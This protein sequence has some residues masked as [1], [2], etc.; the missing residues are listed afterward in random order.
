MLGPG[1]SI[2]LAAELAD[3]TPQQIDEE[4]DEYLA[5]VTSRRVC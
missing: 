1:Q 2:N 3:L 4:L 5:F